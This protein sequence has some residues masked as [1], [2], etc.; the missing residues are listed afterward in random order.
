MVIELSLL[1]PGI[2]AVLIFIIYTGFYYHD[3]SVIENVAYSSVL[4]CGS[5]YLYD[6]KNIS[7]V[8]DDKEYEN[9]VINRF[10]ESI[11]GRVVGKWN[12]DSRAYV[13]NNSISIN[14]NGYMEWPG[15]LILE[16][17]GGHLFKLSINESAMKIYEPN[18]IR[19]K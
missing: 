10:Y 7:V 16:Y 12:L 15:G 17:L 8:C 3:R 14:V 19:R 4:K 13:N 1:M 9:A 2:I 5:G 6:N 18:Y 11:Y